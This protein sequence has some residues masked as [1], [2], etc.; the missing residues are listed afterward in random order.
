MKNISRDTFP[1]VLLLLVN[2]F[3]LFASW[4]INMSPDSLNVWGQVQSGD[5]SN[6]HPVTYTI[7]V[8]IFSF[9]KLIPLK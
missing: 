4:P 9:M 7:F 6:D 1:F 8:N 2:L 3:W 5:Y